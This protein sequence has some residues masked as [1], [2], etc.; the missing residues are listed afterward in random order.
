MI[1]APVNKIIASSVVD[2][3]GNRTAI[4]FQSCNF[5]CRYCHNPETISLCVN[6]GKCVDTCPVKA[7]SLVDGKVVWDEKLCCGCDTC[8]KTCEN[9]ASPKVKYMDADE[10]FEKIK[11]N[12]PFIRGITVSGGECTLQAEVVKQLFRIA[13]QHGLSTLLDSNGS[14]D[15]EK[16]EELMAV[17]D[18]VML[19]VK[20]DNEKRH[21]WLTSYKIDK[22]L[23]NLDYLASIGKLEEVRTVCIPEVLD[24]KATIRVVGKI[25]GPYLQKKDIRY[26]LIKY[27]HFGVREQYRDFKEPD[28]AYME[29][30]RKT[31]EEEGFKNIV[32]I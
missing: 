17:S 30:L 31:A 29:E 23:E 11:D 15:F 12:L 26:K 4:F 1:K 24:A 27:R 19:D 2:G 9:N 21:Q 25:L 5:N 22:V 28:D 7:L 10:I 16:D 20:A 32:I 6:C 18:G 14:Y 3:P 8:I 13:R